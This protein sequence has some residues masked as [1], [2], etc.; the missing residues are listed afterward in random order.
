[1]KL[2]DYVLSGNC[3]KV[4]LLASLLGLQYETVP[5]DF[6][7]GRQHKEEWFLELN[8]LGQLPIIKDNGIIVRDAQA[9]L[10][11]VANR[12]DADKKWW[13]STDAKQ[14]G[15]VAQ[16][17]A[18]ADQITST[19]SAARLHDML[20]YSVDVETARRDAHQI[21]TV[22]EDHLV[23]RELE[24]GEWIVGSN[25]TI[26]D[27]ACFPYTA[28]AGDGGI[29]TSIYPAMLRWHRRVMSLPRFID[30][31]GINSIQ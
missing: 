26:A 8:P 2:Y 17:L 31:P 23:E 9:I 3:Y 12:Y 11:Y 30:M 15:Q 29:D 19:A 4:R 25:P 22:L 6:Y 13:P 7:P 5:I 1:M 27:I 16:W 14:L 21:F 18:F 20:G 10:L 28:L 24:K